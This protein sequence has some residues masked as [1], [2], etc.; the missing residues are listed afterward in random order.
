MSPDDYAWWQL[1]LVILGAIVACFILVGMAPRSV[2]G[3][4]NSFI[5][6][7]GSLVWICILAGII[8]LVF[9]IINFVKWMGIG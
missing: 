5:Y 9:A 4:H 1:L 8:A 7:F 2:E 6:L 3:K